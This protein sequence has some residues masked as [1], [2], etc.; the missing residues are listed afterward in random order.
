MG[1]K[2]RFDHRNFE[3][4]PGSD[5]NLSKWSTK[6]GK[7]LVSKGLAEEALA[8]D[9][10]LLQRAQELL[11]A[12]NRFALL[13]ILQGMDA[14]GKDGMIRHVMSG[15]NP[16]GCRAYPFRAPNEQELK[17][18]FLWRPV[19]YLPERGTISLFNRSYYEEVMVVRVH[20]QFLEP[21]R[22]PQLHGL[23]TKSL[24]RLW[25]QRYREINSFERALVNNGTL[26]M[27]FF[28]HLSPEVQKQRLLDRIT[29]PDKNWKFNPSDL[30]ERR[31]WP[32][33]ET[34]FE[35][36]IKETSTERAPWYIIPAD[37]KWYARAAIA[38]LI[39]SRLSKLELSYP[40]VK[41][42]QRQLYEQLGRELQAES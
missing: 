38:D 24:E 17:H 23:K 33:Y 12:S 6:A 25:K 13:V 5:V 22:L 4:K 3:V 15:V 2:H 16:L 11:Y 42:E 19:A 26:V 21:Q 30:E 18:H 10:E 34:A 31:L 40:E 27:K 20:P 14:S 8:V 36:A 28:L 32:A 9:V 35:E 41:P 37:D 39:A 1:N 29:E 7:D